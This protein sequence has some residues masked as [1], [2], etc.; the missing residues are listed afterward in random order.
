MAFTS[1]VTRNTRQ[2]KISRLSG[3]M[4]VKIARE[5]KDPMYVKLVKYRKLYLE[6][7][8]RIQQ[9]YGMKG[10]Q[11]ARQKAL[12]ANKPEND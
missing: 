9:K 3:A 6:T 1:S 8:K 4:A 2:A 11:A 12:A 5:K 7:K 10:L